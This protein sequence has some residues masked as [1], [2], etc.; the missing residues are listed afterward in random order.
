MSTLLCEPSNCLC[1]HCAYCC[2]LPILQDTS[3][4]D[5]VADTQADP[6]PGVEVDTETDLVLGKEVGVQTEM[7]AGTDVGVQ[8]EL[9]APT[10]VSH[11]ATCTC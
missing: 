3:T 1:P 2:C 10:Q 8:A 6:L 7:L 11:F 9:N 4:A 5:V